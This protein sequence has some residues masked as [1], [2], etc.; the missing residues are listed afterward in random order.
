MCVVQPSVCP[1]H[2]AVVGRGLLGIW[3]VTLV[4]V[5]LTHHRP[6][7]PQWATVASHSKHCEPLEPLIH[8][9]TCTEL[10]TASVILITLKLSTPPLVTVVCYIKYLWVY[11][12][13]KV[14]GKSATAVRWTNKGRY[15]Q[16]FMKMGHG[17]EWNTLTN[18]ETVHLMYS[19]F[20]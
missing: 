16:P 14:F 3:K 2:S 13:R 18:V 8:P 10:V 11:T 4:K 6:T 12:L 9:F 15:S 19:Y 1:L 17:L 7:H 20:Y 5:S